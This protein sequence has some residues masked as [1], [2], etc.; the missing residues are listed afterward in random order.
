MM[1]IDEQHEL[2]SFWQLCFQ[3]PTHVDNHL[4]SPQMNSLADIEALLWLHFG[5]EL[6]IYPSEAADAIIRDSRQQL[7][8]SSRDVRRLGVSRF[9]SSEVRQ[10]LDQARELS[11]VSD[12]RYTTRLAKNLVNPLSLGL[13][14]REISAS[15]SDP[16]LLLFTDLIT[17]EDESKWSN[18]LH[19][20]PNPD[21]IIRRRGDLSDLLFAGFLGFLDHMNS[22]RELVQ[23]CQEESVS[24][25][26]RF[27]LTHRLRSI[28]MWRLDLSDVIVKDRF[29][30]LTGEYLLQLNW[31]E[32]LEYLDFDTGE[33]VKRIEWICAG[34][35]GADS[36]PLGLRPHRPPERRWGTG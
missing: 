27:E 29:T 25:H 23:Y 17:F 33:L 7:S 28:H 31:D 32:E 26:A 36:F 16:L 2:R 11:S 35:T 15:T 34:W 8:A 19:V 3:R 10:F 12:I 22:T 18:L 13:L 6:G 24:D 20:D 4:L 14:F 21:N 1:N 5:V 9:F 30:Q